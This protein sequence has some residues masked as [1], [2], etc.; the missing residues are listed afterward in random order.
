MIF[1]SLPFLIFLPIVLLLVALLKQEQHRRIAIFAASLF[2]Y[3]WWDW[4]FCFF[5]VAA[6]TIDYWLALKIQQAAPIQ[7]RRW[8]LLS[9]AS[10]LGILAAFKYVGWLSH[11][12]N[13]LTGWNLPAVDIPLPLGISFFT[14]QAMSYTI[15]VYRGQFNPTKRWFDFSFSMSFFPHLIAGPIV[16]ASHF[17]PQLDKEHPIERDNLLD[18]LATFSKG[19]LKKTLLA[20]QFAVCADV[21][22]ANPAFFSSGTVWLGVAAYTAQ[23]Y[24][25]F[26]GYTDMAIGLARMFGF[27]FPNNFDHPY[28]SGN[29]TDFWRRWHISLSSWLRDYLYI[30]LGG[31]RK[32]RLRTYV[33]LALTMLLGGLWHG[34]N[35][36]FVVWGGLHGLA[37]AMHK[38]ISE[39]WPNPGQVRRLL[40]VPLTLLF[41]MVCWVFF[42]APS[43]DVASIVLRKMAFIDSVGCDWPYVQALL[44]LGAAIGAHV[45]VAF[46]RRLAFDFRKPIFLTI[47][48][49]ALIID[50]MF[51]PTS[52]GAFIYFQ[53]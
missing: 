3:G 16:R 45:Y 42:R 1:S 37:L 25:D 2:F 15:D 10:N 22:F 27:Q 32:G 21:V 35:W 47:L 38:L 18:G 7:K 14:F 41:V 52:H 28:L 8:L 34:A 50:L 6:S 23:I 43:F 48:V 44:G 40:G 51:A 11:N 46:D 29:I 19:F 24:Y 31:N 53:F 30:S 39:R 20:D 4:R 17:I 12:I 33:N 13:Q 49:V 26:S 36:T 5:L 9:L